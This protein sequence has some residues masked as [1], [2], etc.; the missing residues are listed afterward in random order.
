M[1]PKP[2][3]T[4][5]EIVRT[6]FE[7]TR[8]NGFPS[9]T[10]RELGKQ[11]GTSATPIFTVFHNMYELQKE[12]RAMAMKEFEKYVADALHYTP[13]FKQ[14]GMQM[15]KFA[16]EEPELFR[17]LYMDVNEESRSFE[18]MLQELGDKAGVCI[19][20]IEREYGVS[21]EDAFRLFRQ[22][23]I[24]TFSVC[25]LMV[26]RICSFTEEEISDILG[27]EFQG[28]LFLVKS[29]QYQKIAVLPK[30]K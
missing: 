20:L 23:W 26:N 27:L 10:A 14:F 6:A 22:S 30:N 3:Y 7:M 5:E 17:L 25:V 12:V 11:L 28:A 8:E 1:P 21:H 24:Q 18:K 2:K 15:I 29:G 9:V 4:K 13:A 16:T 19:D